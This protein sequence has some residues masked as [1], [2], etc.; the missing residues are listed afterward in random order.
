MTP[1][2]DLYF[3]LASD[4]STLRTLGSTKQTED[5]LSGALT[6]T[7]HR[8]RPVHHTRPTPTSRP[9]DLSQPHWDR[10]F[11]LCPAAQNRT[12]R[13]SSGAVSTAL[14]TTSHQPEHQRSN[15]AVAWLVASRVG[16]TRSKAKRSPTCSP[17][18]QPIPCC[19]SLAPD[20]DCRPEICN[21][22][23]PGFGVSNYSS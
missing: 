18:F 2:L 8:P 16:L 11:C 4:R 13:G 6:T 10:S 7:G 1:G 12:A 20:V 15:E 23:A 9:G 5:G 19:S 3:K 14:A 17:A 21:K 22:M